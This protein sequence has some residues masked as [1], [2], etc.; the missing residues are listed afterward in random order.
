MV[1]DWEKYLSEPQEEEIYGESYWLVSNNWLN[2][3]V[4][5][6]EGAYEHAPSEGTAYHIELDGIPL[7][8]LDTRQP[9][10]EIEAVK[11]HEEAHI[12][13]DNIELDNLTQES[14]A[15]ARE[16]WYRNQNDMDPADHLSRDV[17]GSI[18]WDVMAS[19]HIEEWTEAY[20]QVASEYGDRRALRSAKEAVQKEPDLVDRFMLPFRSPY[21]KDFRD[22]SEI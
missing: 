11:A 14:I 12:F 16:N 13:I 9:E 2:E 7:V 3:N 5:E 18:F 4:I 17:T 10:D 6:P 19:D 21:L 20:E 1:E 15:T 22:I 8:S